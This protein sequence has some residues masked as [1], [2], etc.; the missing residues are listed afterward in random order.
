MQ[1]FSVNQKLTNAGDKRSKRTIITRAYRGIIFDRNGQAL[2]VSTPIDSIW[3][4][5]YQLSSNYS[6]CLKVFKLLE[7][8]KKKQIEII[9]RVKN[10][11]KQSRFLLFKTP[12][13][14]KNYRKNQKFKYKRYLY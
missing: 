14:S 8:S 12:H 6:E 2:A 5:P 3:I 9:D 1:S 11:Q 4:D 10:N 7:L 13:I